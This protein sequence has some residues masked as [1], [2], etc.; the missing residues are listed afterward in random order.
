[1][2]VDIDNL[3]KRDMA[4]MSDKLTS[5]LSTHLIPP[6]KVILFK[7]FDFQ[8]TGEYWLVTDHTGTKDSGYRVV[9]SEPEGM[10]GLEMTT[11]EGQSVMM[12]LYGDFA[13][14]IESM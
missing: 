13:T 8:A 10:F 14:T 12:G 6:R 1:M 5:W 9:Y 11:K 4:K 7:D 2:K 3:I